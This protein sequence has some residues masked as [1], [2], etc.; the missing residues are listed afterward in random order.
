MDLFSLKEYA[1]SP[2]FRGMKGAFNKILEYIKNDYI[3]FNELKKIISIDLKS[4][5]KK[6]I[7]LL[8]IQKSLKDEEINEI[9]NNIITTKEKIKKQIEF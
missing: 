9:V 2:F 6:K 3:T 5:L 7:E 1:N 8:N 4:Q